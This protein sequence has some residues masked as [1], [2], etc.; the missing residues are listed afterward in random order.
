[1]RWSKPERT[2]FNVKLRFMDCA[3]RMKAKSIQWIMFN[4]GK[5]KFNKSSVPLTRV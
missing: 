5:T 1:M 2:W 4:T 3:H